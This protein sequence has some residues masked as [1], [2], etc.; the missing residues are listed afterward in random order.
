MK[1]T[2]DQPRPHMLHLKQYSQARYVKH[3]ISS[4]RTNIYDNINKTEMQNK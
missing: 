3:A 4:K 1:M 2:P